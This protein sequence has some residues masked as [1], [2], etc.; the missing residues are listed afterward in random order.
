MKLAVPVAVIAELMSFVRHLPNQ[1][2][3]PFGMLTEHEE[4]GVDVFA[5][6]HVENDRGRTGIRPV[7][8]GDA[9][10]G[11][12]VR[13][14]IERGRDNPRVA[15]PGAVRRESRGYEAGRGQPDHTVTATRPI[16]V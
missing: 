3:P 2:R 4:G 11:V 5:A 9:D 6:Q 12:G 7:V 16:T 15:M 8:E 13:K 14:A 10:D 1:L